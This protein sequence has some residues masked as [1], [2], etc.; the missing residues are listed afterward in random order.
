V[1]YWEW[2]GLSGMEEIRK[3]LQRKL[4]CNVGV[5]SPAH[6]RQ[7]SD[8]PRASTQV[9][10]G[11]VGAAASGG[12]AVSES[13]VLS[14]SNGLGLIKPDTDQVS[15]EEEDEKED[16]SDEESVESGIFT[17]S[18]PV[19]HSDLH[20]D[21]NCS[22]ST[23]EHNKATSVARRS[24]ALYLFF[25]TVMCKNH[26]NCK[27]GDKCNFAHGETELRKL[28]RIRRRVPWMIPTS[29]GE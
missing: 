27:Y 24:R 9:G 23:A 4:Q 15:I 11:V 22:P 7:A 8:R 13:V 17:W 5:D 28:D 21:D 14:E 16:D 1:T 20:F 25:K 18:A 2:D 6:S 3:Y 26:P 29:G 12:G 10:G 19:K